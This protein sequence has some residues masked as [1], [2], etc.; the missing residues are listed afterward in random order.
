MTRVPDI[1]LELP[2]GWRWVQR[3]A[4]P[5]GLEPGSGA[6]AFQ[7]SSPASSLQWRGADLDALVRKFAAGSQ[8]GEVLRVT[9]S[10][11]GYGRMVQAE[12]VSDRWGDVAVWMLVHDTHDPLVV[13][14]IAD[15]PSDDGKVARELVRSIA[16]GRFSS[17]VDMIVSTVRADFASTGSV[18][19]HSV[20]VG[21]ATIQTAYFDG[22]PDEI[23]REAMRVETKRTR[24]SVAARVGMLQMQ[25]ADGVHLAAFV[26]VESPS[27]KKRFL[28]PQ[29][30]RGRVA[31]EVSPEGAPI[32][33][34]FLD[35]DPRIAEMLARSRQPPS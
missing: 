11:V 25:R 16:P 20:L 35:A 8:L 28:L 17:T 1:V 15:T 14:W 24:A 30:D 22:M 27:L 31:H 13:T 21:D 23:E 5:L 19:Y 6:G 10:E 33:D 34:F 2:A 9:Q 18:E 4:S 12:L 3:D 29:E 7:I 32:S 26:H